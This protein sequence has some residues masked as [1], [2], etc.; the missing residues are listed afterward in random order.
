MGDFIVCV[1][2]LIFYICVFLDTGS[3]KKKI[4]SFYPIRDYGPI[5]NTFL[6]ISGIVYIICVLIFA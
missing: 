5:T 2:I 1:F 4:K 3:P 6:I